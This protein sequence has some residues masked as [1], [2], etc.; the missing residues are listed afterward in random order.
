MYRRRDLETFL[1]IKRLLYEDQY[2]IAGAKKR[3]SQPDPSPDDATRL[4]SD[5]KSEL[6]S[7]RGLLDRAGDLGDDG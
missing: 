4:L 7:I 5:I 2:T 1:D 6:L 3:L